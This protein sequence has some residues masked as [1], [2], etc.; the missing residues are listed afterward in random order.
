[1]DSRIPKLLLS[2]TPTTACFAVAGRAN[3][4]TLSLATCR[5]RSTPHPVVSGTSRLAAFSTTRS[6]HHRTGK[7]PTYSMGFTL[8]VRLLNLDNGG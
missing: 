5:G 8:H 1:M 3:N 7:Q 2:V 4:A 6:A